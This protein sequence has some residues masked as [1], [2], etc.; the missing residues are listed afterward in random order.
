MD[1]PGKGLEIGIPLRVSS[2]FHQNGDVNFMR[3]PS[4]VGLD[5]NKTSRVV[6]SFLISRVY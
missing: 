2:G 6:K 5:T 4:K 3:V 1:S